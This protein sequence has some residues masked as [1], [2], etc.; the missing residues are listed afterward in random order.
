MN[1]LDMDSKLIDF[2]LL[3]AKDHHLETFATY[4]QKS[5]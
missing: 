3:T 5:L 1:S 4:M 2:Q